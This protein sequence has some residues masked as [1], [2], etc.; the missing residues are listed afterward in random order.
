[1]RPGVTTTGIALGG[2]LA[3]SGLSRLSENIFYVRRRI[4]LRHSRLEKIPLPGLLLG[5]SGLLLG[6]IVSGLRGA[7]VLSGLSSAGSTKWERRL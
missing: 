3:Q 4:H 5:H 7:R 2:A 6:I 1:M